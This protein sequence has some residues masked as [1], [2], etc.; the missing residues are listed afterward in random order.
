MHEY[1]HQGQGAY[2][3]IEGPGESYNTVYSLGIEQPCSV[4]WGSYRF[5]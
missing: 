1:G 2:W 3:D 5:I 4:Y